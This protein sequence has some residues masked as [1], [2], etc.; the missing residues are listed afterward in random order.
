MS[1]LN[2]AVGNVARSD[3]AQEIKEKAAHVQSDL[4]DIGHA[5]RAAVTEGYQQARDTANQYVEDGK[6]RAHEYVDHGKQRV[7]A[8]EHGVEQY[9]HDKPVQALLIAAGVGLLLGVLWR[10]S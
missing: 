5:A 7:E 1:R 6:R 4:R 8:W 3:A 10:K 9:V 2:E